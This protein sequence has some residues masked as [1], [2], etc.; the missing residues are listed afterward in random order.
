MFSLCQRGFP[1]GAPVSPIML[2]H[3]VSVNWSR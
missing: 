3:A 1:P 2:K